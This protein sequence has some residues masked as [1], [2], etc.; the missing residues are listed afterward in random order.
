MKKRIIVN[1]PSMLVG[2]KSLF[3]FY[4]LLDHCRQNDIELVINNIFDMEMSISDERLKELFPKS[5]G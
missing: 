5:S 1:N 4:T 2:G 3:M